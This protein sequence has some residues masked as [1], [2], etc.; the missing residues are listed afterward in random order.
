MNSGN[1]IDKRKSII[2]RTLTVILVLL[3]LAGLSSLAY[4]VAN[5]RQTEYFSEFYILGFE[6]KAENYP[7]EFTMS[8]G[9]IIRIYYGSGT[10][11]AVDGQDA[12]VTLGVS[13]QEK[14]AAVYWLSASI[15][16][17]AINLNNSPI[18]G[19]IDLDPGQKLDQIVRFTPLTVGRDQIVEFFLYEGR[20]DQLKD[21]LRL[22]I[23]VL[24]GQ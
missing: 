9:Q 3:I 19:P 2:S 12:K 1:K 21:R 10:D 5:P 14:T 17:E 16:G 15:N 23:D 13:N 7:K 20:Q 22:H 24:E 6:G 18:I 11:H 8:G 4:Y